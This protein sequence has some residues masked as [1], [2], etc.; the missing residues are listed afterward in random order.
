MKKIILLA[1]ITLVLNGCRL[2]KTTE[3]YLDAQESQELTIPAEIDKPNSTATLDIPS[4]KSNKVVSENSNPAP[5]DMPIRTKQS[6][7][8]KLRISNDDGF[9]I[10]TV[11][12]D[13][14]T[15]WQ[16]MTSIVVE[17]W[18]ITNSDKSTCAVNLRYEDKA[19]SERDDD[20]FLKKLFRRDKLYK[21]HSGDFN[22]NCTQLDSSFKVKFSTAD[23]SR[24]SSYLVDNI[25][26]DLYSK[27]E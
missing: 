16:A 27:L 18:T 2:I 7:D 11:S 4:I 3:P 5:P 14:D 9:P 15:V 23:G 22:L 24:A 1:M 21:D 13:L 26:E 20:G 10:I 17:G 19:A 6:D 8:G 25:M 12:T